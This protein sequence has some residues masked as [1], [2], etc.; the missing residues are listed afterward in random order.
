MQLALLAPVTA[1]AAVPDAGSATAHPAGDWSPSGRLSEL[2]HA[3]AGTG[4]SYALDPALLSAA[5]AAAGRGQPGAAGTSASPTP[6]GSAATTPATTPGT[7][8]VTPATTGGAPAAVPAAADW[9]QL[10]N[11]TIRHRDVVA[12][13][14][15]D[16]DIAAVAHGDGPAL[17]DA[18]DDK[19]RATFAAVLGHKAN[20]VLWPAKGHLDAAGAA[21]VDHPA[22]PPRGARRRGPAR[23]GAGAGRPRRPRRERPAPRSSGGPSGGRGPG[24]RPAGGDG[25]AGRGSPDPRGSGRH[26]GVR[27]GPGAA[28]DGAADWAPDATAV[29]RLAAG[30][31]DA[32]WVSLRSF[33]TLA[34]VGGLGGHADRP[35]AYSRAD[36]RR[37]LPVSHVAAVAAAERR[38]A[39]FAPALDQRDRIV[40]PLVQQGLSL[41]GLAWRGQD[42]GK[43]AVAR[44]PLTTAID[45]LYFGISI[46]PGSTKNLLAKEGSLP[47]SV[48]NTLPYD[49]HVRL[50]LIPRTGQLAI[51]DSYNVFLQAGTSQQVPVA[52]KAIANGDVAVVPSFRTPDD[53]TMLYQAPDIQVR[54][55]S[56]WE[57][58][59]VVV[60]ALLLG[61]LLAVGLFRGARRDRPR[62]PPEAVPDPDDI[63]RVPVPDGAGDATAED[64]AVRG[65]R[66]PG[67]HPPR[68]PRRCPRPAAAW[69]GPGPPIPR[70]TRSSPLCPCPR[71]RRRRPSRRAWADAPWS[72]RRPARGPRR[73]RWRGTTSS[74]TGDRQARAR[75]ATLTSRVL[76]Q[77]PDPARP[78][79]PPAGTAR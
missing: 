48:R 68:T 72:R 59:G 58:R 4:F 25:R 61:L 60:V 78:P 64:Q 27:T 75:Q 12:L 31:R 26:G 44:T 30:L 56:D 19:A 9:L 50:V 15:A 77:V 20:T 6:S 73:Q 71:R 74:W 10:L 11:T 18:A 28:R 52:V 16:P 69:W 62:I 40:P 14:W 21:R 7:T 46:D 39:A 35:I 38:L 41:L 42:A 34:A 17:V 65:E 8:P 47:I 45:A 5:E 49:V 23:A 70:R 32:G 79:R 54:V 43:L 53:K 55:R 1:P 76:L 36:R 67:R 29:A 66:R 22:G 37:E 33:S 3:T 63:G 51:P 24:H 13:P 2:L 57:G